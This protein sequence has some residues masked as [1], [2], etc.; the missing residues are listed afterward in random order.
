MIVRIC[1]ERPLSETV[2]GTF[3]ERFPNYDRLSSARHPTIEYLEF[4]IEDKNAG[5]FQKMHR[6]LDRRGGK[7]T[8]LQTKTMVPDTELGAS[9]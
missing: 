7:I 3:K 1:V 4:S 8:F 2:L 5:E 9:L 6:T